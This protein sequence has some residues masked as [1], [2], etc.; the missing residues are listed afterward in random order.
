VFAKPSKSAR[1]FIFRTNPSM[2]PA[3]SSASAAQASLAEAISVAA[4]RART[5]NR[6]PAPSLSRE[7]LA[8][9]ADSLTVTTCS[10]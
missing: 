3:V 8:R 10:G 1:S 6:S 9:A 4:S 2:L 5:V 7:P